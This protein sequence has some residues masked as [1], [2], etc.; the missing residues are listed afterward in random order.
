M[1]QMTRWLYSCS[2]A[3]VESNKNG[4]KQL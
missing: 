1:K 3:H 2:W 4:K